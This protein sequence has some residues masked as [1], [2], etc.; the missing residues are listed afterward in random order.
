MICLI[1]GVEFPERV[2]AEPGGAAN[3]HATATTTRT[4]AITRTA[5]PQPVCS[6]FAFCFVSC[7][8]SHVVCSLCR[9]LNCAHLSSV[10]REIVASLVPALSWSR[11]EA[12]S[13]VAP[14]LLIRLKPAGDALTAEVMESF[15]ELYSSLINILRSPVRSGSQLL[16]AALHAFSL[17]YGDDDFAMVRSRVLSCSVHCLCLSHF[18]CF[19]RCC[20]L[21]YSPC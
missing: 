12:L 7:L 5:H 16:Q 20:N 14:E 1:E 10:K 8:C 19:V 9:F 17:K 18:V 2:L 3:G 4:T 6:L 15:R 13:G 11:K 21:A